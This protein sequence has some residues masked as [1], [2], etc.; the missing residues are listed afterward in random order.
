MRLTISVSAAISRC[1]EPAV[2]AG[3]ERLL[4]HPVCRPLQSEEFCK[5]VS[6]VVSGASPCCRVHLLSLFGALALC[7]LGTGQA[8][9]IPSPELVVG[10]FVSISQLFALASAVLGG[11]AAYA[12]MRA[13]RRGGSAE[14]SRGLLYT[15]VGLFV[16]LAVS[17]GFN[18]W[19][20]VSRLQRA[21]G[22]S[23]SDADAAD[24]EVRWH[25]ARRDVEGGEL[26]RAAAQSAR[27]SHREMEKLLEANA[28]GERQDTIPA[29]YPRDG[30]NRDGHHARRQDDS[31]PG[32]QILGHRLHRQD[33]H[34]V[35][36][37]RQPRL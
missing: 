26:R 10:S 11:G 21:A 16:V 23:R 9:A 29:R 33:R 5:C 25:G 12:T 1:M 27:H 13:R 30:G 3:P 14:M 6:V 2:S 31:L 18:I 8:F 20:Y 22:T 32:R 34:P 35:L 4:P 36:P 17:I 28:R 15:T 19:Q 24:A 7:L 37:Q